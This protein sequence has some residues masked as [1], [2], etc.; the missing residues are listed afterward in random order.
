MS[1]VSD[2][3]FANEKIKGVL[4]NSIEC[5]IRN[6]ANDEHKYTYWEEL[7]FREYEINKKHGSKVYYR[8]GGIKV[9]IAPE[10]DE[11]GQKLLNKAVEIN[12]KLF[13]VDT[14]HYNRIFE[15]RHS[16]GNKYHGFRREDISE[17][18]QK[19]IYK[20]FFIENS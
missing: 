5:E 11:L 16:Y 19:R 12:G 4:N 3:V 9:D 7:G 14:E 13:S 18:L 15:F 20:E 2:E 6:I 17:D 8:S 1:L 10:T